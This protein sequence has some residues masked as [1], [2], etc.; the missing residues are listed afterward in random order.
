MEESK[1][2]NRTFR[3][4]SVFVF[5]GI[6]MTSACKYRQTNQGSGMDKNGKM[7]CFGDATFQI[8]WDDKK[9]NLDLFV[10]NNAG[11]EVSFQKR[12]HPNVGRMFNTHLLCG[13]NYFANTEIIIQ[14]KL[15]PGSYTISAAIYK[16]EKPSVTVYTTIATQKEGKGLKGI[17]VPAD[18]QPHI[19]G[20]ITMDA[21]GNIQ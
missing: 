18:K 6:M 15:I 10:K 16:S 17:D 7:I 20:Q 19:I 2:I 1:W 11:G 13:C 21:A 4:V 14:P 12:S 3:L 5:L 8:L 9:D